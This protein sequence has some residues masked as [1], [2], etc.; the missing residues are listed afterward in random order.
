MADNYKEVCRMK[1]QVSPV[2]Y[3][4]GASCALMDK[5]RRECSSWADGDENICMTFEEAC[6]VDELKP[7]LKDHLDASDVVLSL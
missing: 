4:M 2:I 1:I 5:V 6:E 7:L 3:I